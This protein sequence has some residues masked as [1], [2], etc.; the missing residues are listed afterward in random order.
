MV[1]ENGNATYVTSFCNK[2]HWMHNGRPE[3]HECF[4]LNPRAL[5]L[6]RAGSDCLGVVRTSDRIVNGRACKCAVCRK[7]N[8]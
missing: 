2:S 6:E 7:E 5:T 1:H 3:G 8:P 4:V